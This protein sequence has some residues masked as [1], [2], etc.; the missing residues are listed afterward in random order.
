MDTTE[1]IEESI[2]HYQELGLKFSAVYSGFL[3]NP[4]QVDTVLRAIS[5]LADDDALIVIDPV[6]ADGGKLYDCYDSSMVDAMRRLVA[7]ADMIC[8]NYTEG[9]LLVDMDPLA[10]ASEQT[11]IDLC[12]KLHQLGPDEITLTSVSVHGTGCDTL[13]SSKQGDFEIFPC[14]YIPCYYTGTGDIFSAL[15][16]ANSLAGV[17]LKSAIPKVVSFITSAIKLSQKRNQGSAWG[18]ALEEIISTYEL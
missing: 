9:C 7:T 10:P 16:V 1:F 11:L 18:V 8:P 13:Y 4:G 3:G 15:M 5:S 12:A 14:E 17:P 6:M 2:N